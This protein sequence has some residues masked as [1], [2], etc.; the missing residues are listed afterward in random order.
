MPSM[1]TPTLRAITSHCTSG[2][3]ESGFLQETVG[4]LVSRDFP[5]PPL[6]LSRTDGVEV[7]SYY[8]L[9]FVLLVPL[10]FVFRFALLWRTM[11]RIR[12]VRAGGV[13][14]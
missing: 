8:L 9:A 10:L 4:R 6:A 11:S 7:W 13:A 1:S 5:L 14:R 12:N 3:Q 2:F